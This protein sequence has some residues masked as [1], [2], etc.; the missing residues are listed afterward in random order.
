MY[1]Q[2][3]ILLLLI[4]ATLSVSTSPII[5]KYLSD[6]PSVGISFWRMAIGAMI[7]WL[8]SRFINVPHLSLKNSYYTIIAGIFLGIH[9]Q[10]FFESIKLT[11]I[12]NAT[13]LGT[14]A[15]LFTL[16]IEKF[17]LKRLIPTKMIFALIIIFSG[18][19]IIVG[20]QFDPSSNYTRGNL[21]ALFCSLWIAL[22]IIISENVRKESNTIAISRTLF[23]SAAVT[24]LV[25]SFLNGE[26]LIGYSYNDY[27]G[28]FFLGLIP[29]IFGHSTFYYALKYVQPT[30]VASFP[31]GEPIIASIAAYFL[32]NEL[33]SYYIILGGFL[34]V[35]GLLILVNL[36]KVVD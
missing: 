31:L 20:H 33:V 29:T 36:K 19:L 21:Y 7:M 25:I 30:I 15:P 34:T 3:K 9:F 1:T 28:L 13:F 16:F 32:F 27:L 11:T 24:L 17:W 5:A 22:T 26:S 35:I 10:F 18:S 14:L 2:Y 12:A 4:F 8:Y 23:S 6:I